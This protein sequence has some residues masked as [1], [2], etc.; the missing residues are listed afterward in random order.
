[1]MHEPTLTRETTSLRTF[2][3]AFRLAGYDEVFPAGTYGVITRKPVHESNALTTYAR[4]TTI[5][6][7]KTPVLTRL[8]EVDPEAF[9]AAVERDSWAVLTPT[10]GQRS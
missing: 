6:L 1:M 2:R 8:C 4:T 9:E 3:A 10:E 7:V 5:L